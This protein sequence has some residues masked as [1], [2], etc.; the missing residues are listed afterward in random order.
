M[1]KMYTALALSALVFLALTS[2]GKKEQLEDIFPEEGV[3]VEVATVGRAQISTEH[4]ISGLVAAE[5]AEGIY[6]SIS[7]RCISV[8]LEQ[9]DLVRAGEVICVLDL[10]SYRDNY[11]LAAL[12]YENARQSHADQSSLLSQQI[13]QAEKHYQDTLALFE[14]G[15]ASALEV[16]SAKINWESALVGRTSALAQ[17]EL[18]MKSAQANMNQ[19][20]DALQ[21]VDMSG[22]VYAP[23]SGVISS[24]TVAKNAFVSPGMPLAV[25]SSVD[26]RKVTIS[27]S[28]SLITKLK[29]GDPASISIGALGLTFSSN[30]LDVSSAT[31]QMSSLYTVNLSVPAEQAAVLNGMFADVTLFTDF[32]EDTVVIPTEAIQ[33]N[34]A[35]NYVVVLDEESMAH[36]IPIQTGL[37]GDGVTEVLSGLSGGETLVTVGQSYLNEGDLAR[38]V[39][40]KE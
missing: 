5:K 32:K 1:K 17:L 2:C 20:T 3:A 9:G 13:A 36:R 7:A 12:N 34:E 33:I 39:L 11:E 19:I 35:G 18:A 6:V 4:H 22:N 21:N 27:V 14:I 38:V 10:G 31:D 8:P 40:V 28:E 24:L 15:A 23:I 30:I 16:D 25:I 26:E 29:P 37:V